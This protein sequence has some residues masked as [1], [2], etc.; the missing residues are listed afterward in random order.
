MQLGAQSVSA[1]HAR[2]DGVRGAASNQVCRPRPGSHLPALYGVVFVKK[3]LSHLL[4]HAVYGFWLPLIMEL[5]LWSSNVWLLYA[6][7]FYLF[8]LFPTTFF[9]VSSFTLFHSCYESQDFRTMLM[10]CSSL[11]LF[12]FCQERLQCLTIMFAIDVA[13]TFSSSLRK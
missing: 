9:K 3:R 8:F 5:S 12:L 10:A 11:S 6:N 7:R 4:F 1:G 13:L 2:L